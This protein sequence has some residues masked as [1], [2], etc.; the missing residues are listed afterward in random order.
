MALATLNDVK[1]VLGINLADSSRDAE[2]QQVL[3][4]IELQL[5][6][7]LKFKY[8]GV[9]ST[10]RFWNVRDDELLVLPAREVTV[11]SVTGDAIAVTFRQEGDLIQ[12]LGAGDWTYDELVVRINGASTVPPDLRLGVAL[13]AVNQLHVGKVDTGEPMIVSENL[14]D[15]SYTIKPSELVTEESRTAAASRLLKPY[16]RRGVIVV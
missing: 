3:D 11:S 9:E 5:Q 15:Y 8:D 12:L 14:G 13:L 16:L 7:R 2:I 1:R 6:R 10:V 4:A